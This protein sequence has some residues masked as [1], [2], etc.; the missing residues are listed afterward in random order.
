[1]SRAILVNCRSDIDFVKNKF[2]SDYN[3]FSRN[4]VTDFELDK[5]Q[6][7][8]NKYPL[9]K[10]K[11]SYDF[12]VWLALN[13]FRD[14][15]GNDLSANEG[16]SLGNIIARR[17]LSAFANDYRNY[18]SIKSIL[19]DNELIYA[20]RSESLSFKRV[21]KIFNNRIQYYND[22]ADFNE[23]FTP[24]PEFTKSYIF[25]DVHPFSSIARI[26]QK[27]F[28]IFVKKRPILNIPDWTSRDVWKYRNDCL[29]LNSL[30]PWNGYYYKKIKK[31]D[32]K[33]NSLFPEDLDNT[34]LD[35]KRLKKLL[36]YKWNDCDDDL[37]KH[38]IN[39][40]QEEYYKA[41]EIFKRTY[42]IF[43]EILSYYSPK[44]IVIPGETH[45]GY[46]IAAQIARNLNIKTVLAIDGYQFVI[47][48]SLLYKDNKNQK[49]IFDKFL[50]YNSQHK[51]ILT[52]MGVNKESCF[53]CISPILKKQKV[54][55]SSVIYDAIVM[56]YQPNQ[57]N[58][59]ITWDQRGGIIADIIK[60]L[61][62][63]NYKKIGLKIKDGR[64][65][66]IY[67]QQLLNNYNLLGNIDLLI[68]PTWKYIN[69]TKLVIGQFSTALLE[70][71][72]NKIP[73][74]VYEPFENG[75][76]EEMINSAIVFNRK[77]ISRNI[78]EL[79]NKL[80]TNSPSIISSHENMFNIQSLSQISTN[81]FL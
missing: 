29:N 28:M 27:P 73:Y 17:I 71:S 12:V 22:K 41:R 80:N 50:A 67:Y 60:L 74:F 35:I 45:F 16:I 75:K 44:S 79:N 26:L 18:L 46:V 76:T 72:Y 10:D 57:H 51:S 54:V 9:A 1:M 77:S 53:V 49:F 19:L 20:S 36:L 13:W 4:I 34:I 43:E 8:F 25:P 3:I 52:S 31:V 69:S 65:D 6:I 23:S 48:R 68:N 81:V 24:D 15:N 62:S 33:L 56:S 61:K 40:L 58:P 70:F 59:Q 21:S 42:S 11:N 32:G 38:F 37:L 64:N 39:L 2:S 7:L 14:E 47:D 5:K 78:R 63:K 30:F 55:E 66:K